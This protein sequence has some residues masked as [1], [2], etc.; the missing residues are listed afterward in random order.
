MFLYHLGQGTAL[1]VPREML[2]ELLAASRNQTNFHAEPDRMLQ[3][4][5]AA[6]I[7]GRTGRW[8]YAHA[9]KLGGKRLSRRCL[10]F[11]ESAIRRRMGSRQ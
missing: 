4:L 7:L 9:D 10:R 6:D 1:P 2:L 8:V 5:Q 11:P 3:A